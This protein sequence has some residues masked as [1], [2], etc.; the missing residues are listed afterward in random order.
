MAERDMQPRDLAYHADVG[1]TTIYRYLSGQRAPHSDILQRLAHALAVP[2]DEL[3]GLE[4]ARPAEEPDLRMVKLPLLSS[5]SGGESTMMVPRVALPEIDH[6]SLAV[7]LA[8]ADAPEL[9]PG[10]IAIVARD[11][12]WEDGDLVVVEDAGDYIIRRAYAEPDDQV[13]IVGAE[14]STR[15]RLPRSDVIARVMTSIRHY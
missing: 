7:A 10:E 9:T 13:L 2:T 1:I 3:L 4:N 15:Q 11:H 5:S 12:P 8:D 14:L 6:E